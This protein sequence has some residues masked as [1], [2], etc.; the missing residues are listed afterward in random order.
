MEKLPDLK[1]NSAQYLVDEYAK[2]H[3]KSST[4][5]RE[6]ISIPGWMQPLLPLPKRTPNDDTQDNADKDLDHN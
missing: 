3:D 5:F 4:P 2:R 1:K 6:F